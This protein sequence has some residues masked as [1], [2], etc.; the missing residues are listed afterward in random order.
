M[1]LL[2]FYSESK[3]EVCFDLE[4]LVMPK[5]VTKCPNQISTDVGCCSPIIFSPVPTKPKF[6]PN[7]SNGC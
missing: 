1:I 3:F 4:P 5:L 6:F 2:N 7:V